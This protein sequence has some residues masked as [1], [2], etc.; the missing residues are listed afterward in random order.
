[1]RYAAWGIVFAILAIGSLLVVA[2]GA[3]PAPQAEEK[4][5]ERE[6]SIHYALK[7]DGQYRILLTAMQNTEL[8][9]ILMSPGSRTFFAPTDKAFERV[10]KLADLLADR[11]HLISVL[12]RHLIQDRSIDTTELSHMSIIVPKEGKELKVKAE[13]SHIEINDARIVMPDRRTKNG[14]V[15]GIDHVLMDGNDSLLREAGE[16]IESGLKEG[17]RKVKETFNGKDDG[18]TQERNAGEPAK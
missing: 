13:K 3:K 11:A 10:P 4:P 2:E 15:H 16:K 12:N 6:E 1:M 17:A 9:T 18:G 7:A 14:I 8:E 5:V